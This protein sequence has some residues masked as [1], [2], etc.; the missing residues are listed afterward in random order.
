[1][2][3]TRY[4]IVR[5]EGAAS[6]GASVGGELSVGVSVVTVSGGS[7]AGGGADGVVGAGGAELVTRAEVVAGAATIVD[8][9]PLWMAHERKIKA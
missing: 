8:T 4:V 5:G 3:V 1:M 2:P 9:E 7:A 6:V